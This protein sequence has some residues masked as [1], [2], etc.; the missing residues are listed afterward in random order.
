MR[1]ASLAR[2]FALGL[3]PLLVSACVSIPD[4]STLTG[5]SLDPN[6]YRAQIVT[7][8]AVVFEDDPL[9]ADGREQVASALKE[10]AASAGSDETNTIARQLAKELRALASGV[11]RTRIGTPM[12]NSPLEHQWLRIRS[13][14]FA[15]AAWFRRSSADPIEPVVPAP[16]KTLRAASVQERL[17]V[18]VAL[19]SLVNVL[20][21][22]KRD[23]PNGSDNARDELTRD[24][25]RLGAKPAFEVDPHYRAAHAEALEAIRNL[26]TV[27]GLSAGASDSSRQSQIERAEEHVRSAQTSLEKMQ[28]V[29]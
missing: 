2:R 18:E 7:I 28:P 10:I 1:S 27:A 5:D 25:Q 15:D 20:D 13:S 22:A 16:P 6:R 11:E 29:P 21:D 9:S 14:L 19:S 12:N 26:R 23:F 17:G 4:V 24:V 3:T 8:D